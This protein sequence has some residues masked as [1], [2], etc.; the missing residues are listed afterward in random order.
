MLAEAEAVQDL[1]NKICLAKLACE[2]NG[3][4]SVHTL[5]ARAVE[6]LQRCS[7]DELRVHAARVPGRIQYGRARTCYTI[8]A[9]ARP[10]SLFSLVTWSRPAS[11]LHTPE[12]AAWMAM[13]FTSRTWGY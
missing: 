9:F 6:I 4:E 11:K 13:F 7:D 5:T 2:R 12:R 10:A 8:S 3:L 1:S